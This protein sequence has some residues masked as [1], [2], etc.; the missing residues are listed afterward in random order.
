MVAEHTVRL[1]T[2]I[3]VSKKLVKPL[4][5]NTYRNLHHYSLNTQKQNF[6]EDVKKL[7]GSIPKAQKIW[8]HYQIFAPTNGR[9][10]TMNVGSIVDKYFSDTLVEAKVIPDD[11]YDHVVFNSFSFGGVQK[12]DGHAIA[13]IFILEEE[14]PMRVLLDQND[15]Q[16]ALTTYVE[17]MKLPGATGVTL[18]VDGEDIVAEVTFG[19]PE[20][21]AEK[22]KTRRRTTKP[23]AKPEPKAEEV[24][25]EPTETAGEGSNDSADTA[26]AERTEDAAPAGEEA[27]DDKGSKKGNLFGDED[28]QSSDSA[29]TTTSD[30]AEEEAPA[31]PVKT[32]KKSSIFDVD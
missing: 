7:L 3:N 18:S 6:H 30:P 11:N 4:N 25:D 31:E 17:G 5:L 12:M 13:T 22:P 23:K 26:E 9:L 29:E 10:D 8:I 19:E 27:S 2:R 15:I 28:G 21:P 14:K 1:P 16:T 20:A 24:T 32:K